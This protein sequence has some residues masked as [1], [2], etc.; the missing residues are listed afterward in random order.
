MKIREIEFDIVRTLAV[1]LILLHH[2]PEHSVNFYAFYLKGH[3]IDLNFVYWQEFY[4][5]VGL[6]VFISGYLLSRANPS[7]ERWRNIKQ[8]I[9]ERYAR[10]FPLYIIALVLF[11]ALDDEIRSSINISTFILD[12]LGLEITFG[13]NNS[14]S[15][16]TLWFVGLIL[17]YYYVFIILQKFGQ[18][19]IRFITLVLVLLFAS[20]LL[21]KIGLMDERFLFFLGIFVASMLAA[22]YKLIEKMKFKH[23]IFVLPIF[24]ILV[25]FFVDFIHLKGFRSYLSLAG[26]SDLVV[27]NLIILGLVFLIFAVAKVI[28][29]TGQHVLVQRMAYASYCIYLFHRPVWWLMMDLYNPANGKIKVLY[30]GLL[31]I[32][33]TVFASYHL[34]KFYDKYFRMRLIKGLSLKKELPL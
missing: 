14:H 12:V 4:V 8:F 19:T 13:P 1:F 5:G 17:S 32:P 9:L 15:L 27:R 33:L 20:A 11:I 26:M 28:V 25:Y 34:Q 16:L 7:F 10:I 31:G 22:K 2:L 3:P 6:F 23:V 30:L 29:R 18:G 24:V 21:I